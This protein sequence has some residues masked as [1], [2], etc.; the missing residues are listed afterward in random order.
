VERLALAALCGYVLG[1]IPTAYLV[2]RWKS[3]QDIRSSGSGNVGTVNSYEVTKS[4]FV[5]AIVLILDFAK[6]AA[7]V[8]L[9]RQ[10][11]GHDSDPG[12]WGGLGAVLGHNYP[13][14]LRGKGGR[15]LATGA[16]V[17]SLLFW[18][19]IPTWVTFWAVAYAFIRRVNPASA[20]ACLLTFVTVL[21]IPAV[22]P[23]AEPTAGMTPTWFAGA[24]VTL[25]LLRLIDPVRSY[26]L[27]LKRQ[28]S[29][30]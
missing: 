15:G 19:L 17:S 2:V 25:I 6:G 11:F 23:G 4:V 5:A 22:I 27:E 1:S 10:L 7:A 28:R 30:Q 14:W 21:V 20:V 9:V 18:G 13:V 8:I 29:V 16:G 3:Q 12:P 26:V 24:L